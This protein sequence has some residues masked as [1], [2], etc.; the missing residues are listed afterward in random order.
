MRFISNFVL[1]W[2]D[3]I[4][5]DDW[6]V[7]VGVVVALAI[8]ALL[9][10]T[11]M[12][13]WWVMPV[14]VVLPPYSGVKSVTSTSL[15]ETPER[16]MPAITELKSAVLWVKGVSSYK[17]DF[18]VET[19]PTSPWIHQPFEDYDTLRPDALLKRFAV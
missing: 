3:F 1:F 2:Y 17:P 12:A 14:A 6:V 8:S 11:G 18:Y 19:L 5:G 4:V 15:G 10:H 7:A 9:A 13:A 16:C